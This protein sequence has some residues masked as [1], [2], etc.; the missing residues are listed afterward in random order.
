[1]NTGKVIE[2]LKGL[3]LELYNE[4]SVKTRNDLLDALITATEALEKQA[5]I[6]ERF[7]AID[8]VK[9]ESELKF[10]FESKG[11]SFSGRLTDPN[12]ITEL[13]K[14]YANSLRR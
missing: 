13:L 7:A 10:N 1:M 9:A 5:E 3:F 2:I 4:G 6:Y 12:Q 14:I 11:I 8:D